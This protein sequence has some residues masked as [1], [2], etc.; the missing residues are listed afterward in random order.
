M[1]R[2]RPASR[3]AIGDTFDYYPSDWQV[4]WSSGH[5]PDISMHDDTV[6]PPT[7]PDPPVKAE[8]LYSYLFDISP[9]PA[10]VSRLQDHTVIAVNARTSEV[11]GIAQTDAVGESVSDYYVD[12]TE[13]TQLADRLRRDGRA[14]NLRL[15]I[16]RRSGEPFWALASSRLITWQTEPAILTVFQD[17]TDQVVVEASLKANERRLIAQS[18]AL[19]SLTAR[20]TDPNDPLD[21]RL[22]SILEISADALVVERLS[23][24]R[25]IDAG[26]GLR[27]DGLYRRSGTR[28]ESGMVLRRPETPSY[29]A[30][31]ERERVIAAD[32]ARTDPR[33]REFDESYLVP[34]GIGAMLDVPLRHDNTTVGVL[35]AEHVGG[36]RVWQVDEQNFAIAVANLIVVAIVEEERQRALGRLAESETRARLVIDTAHDAFVGINS[37]GTVTA[38]NAQAERTFGWSRGEVVGKNLADT[39]VPPAF[40][41]AHNAGLRRF[42]AT[43]DAPVVNQRL[44]LAAVH[45]SGREFPVELTITSPMP[46]EDGFF[47]GAFLRDISDRRERD[48]ELRRAKE[49]AEAATRAKSEFLANM[50]HELRT[51]LNGVLGY[52]QLLQRD[53]A[54]NATQREALDAIATCGSQLLDLINDVLDLSKIEAGRLDIEE[55]PTDLSALVADIRYVLADAADRKG[56]PLIMTVAADVPPLV[57]LDGRHLRQVLLN[58]LGNAVKFTA[59]GDVRLQI[60]RAEADGL[61]FEVM[62][63]GVGIEPESLTQIF[64]AFSQTRTGAAAGGTGLGLTISDHLV[65]RMGGTLAVESVLGQGSR[66]WFVLPFSE[67]RDLSRARPQDAAV[68]PPLDARLAPGQAITALVVDDSTA[69]R[70]ILA[71]LLE[72]AGVRVISAAGGLEAIEMARSHRPGIVFMDLKMDDLDG[73]EVTRRL[74]RDPVTAAIPVVAVTASAIGDVRQKAREAGCVDYLSKPI[75]AQLLFG[76]LQTHL[77]V[78]FVTAAEPVPAPAPRVESLRLRGDIGTRLNDAVEIGD[79]SGLQKLA[80]ELTSAG[81]DEA[82]VGEQIARLAATF[83]FQ[84]LRDLAKSLTL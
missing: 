18:D 49:S 60:S 58:L 9:F 10:V 57:V 81:G 66:F 27:C 70:H 76:I 56:L 59:T 29:F 37:A 16:K 35:C 83:D 44:E 64:S 80:H 53:R 71:S 5:G 13:R 65:R 43:G 52:S 68:V 28:H 45:R 3:V 20:Y 24:W 46:A 15:R 38:W 6:R 1:S 48:A 22:R 4:T 2:R 11:I 8:S 23:M 30:A 7:A 34:L 74:A 19:T 32:D 78:R 61:L 42:H 51:P 47:F 36:G 41:E 25:F 72:S 62:D 21:L 79:V 69:N 33:T 26:E 75:R 84:G 50:S 12:P 39:I 67:G 63:T 55:A 73:L 40:R 17:I 14:D 82:A 77:G 31:L 54:L